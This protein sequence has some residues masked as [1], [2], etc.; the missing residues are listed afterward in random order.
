MRILFFSHYYA[1]EGNAPASRVTALTRR[2]A[3]QG[4]EVTVITCAP[5]VPSGKVYSGYKNKLYQTE[6]ID[7]VRVIRVWTYIAPNRG[8]VRRISNYLSYMFSA[9]FVALFLSRPDVTIAT[10]PQFFCGWAGVLFQFF[11]GGIFILEVRDIWPESISAV[12]AKMP[13]WLLK[14]IILMERIMYRRADHIVT[15][16]SGYLEKLVERQVAR[17]KVAV[18]MNGVDSDIFRPSECNKAFLESWGLKDKFVCSYIG[19]I[20]MA[21]GLEVVLAA[22][23]RLKEMLRSDIA[24]L[25]VGD[26]AV[27]E[28]L[29]A[30]AR[31]RQLDNVVFAGLRPKK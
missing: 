3:E 7:Q 25:L 15:V 30:E 1:P 26:G 13:N 4:H 2:W 18:V 5:N 9:L 27:R 29:E 16:G 23:A 8:I 12:E 28:K 11:K 14:P 20:G 19:T 22:A 21:C 24:F 6:F 10:S 31:K 17:E